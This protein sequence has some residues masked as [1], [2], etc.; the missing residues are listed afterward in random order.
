MDISKVLN[1]FSNEELWDLSKKIKTVLSKR[2]KQENRLIT[3]KSQD[4][5]VRTKNFCEA[6]G[7]KTVIELSYWKRSDFESI[8]N[9]GQKT[10]IE[11]DELLRSF[12]Y[13]WMD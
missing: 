3:I 7:I 4:L 10:T 1:K 5:S 8:K 9:V 11:L 2:A 6:H 12:G 13:S